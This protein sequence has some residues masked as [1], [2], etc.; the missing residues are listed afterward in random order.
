[1][2]HDLTHPDYLPPECPGWLLGKY[3]EWVE[4]WRGINGLPEVW[5][6][7]FAGANALNVTG[8]DRLQANQFVVHRA[9]T[10]DYLERDFTA[11][12][13]D[14]VVGTFPELEAIAAGCRENSARPQSWIDAFLAEIRDR[15]V[16]PEVPPASA[17]VDAGRNFSEVEILASGGGWCNEQARIFIRLCQISGIPARMV[18]Y[19]YSNFRS[20]H[21]VAEYRD[22]AG[23]CLVD[24]TYGCHYR[25]PNGLPLSAASCH[26]GGEG[27]KRYGEIMHQRIVELQQ[28]AAAMIDPSA[29]GRIARWL[30]TNRDSTPSFQS[31]RLH[32]YGVI[33]Y[34]LP[35]A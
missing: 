9:E 16:H 13:V 4:P 17:P 3:P 31:S 20:G 6:K 24:A 26:D 22:P 30:E 34:P 10:A 28:D 18:H 35:P 33:N 7:T 29:L 8:V 1:M 23:W 11:L 19:F 12:E 5:R 25:T 27:Q 2:E 15:V 32:T 21:T 14:Y